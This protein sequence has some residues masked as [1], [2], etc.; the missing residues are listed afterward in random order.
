M[1][2]Q[3]FI[4][5][6]RQ[7]RELKKA[8][9][10]GKQEEVAGTISV[11]TTSGTISVPTT[12]TI[13]ETYISSPAGGGGGGGGSSGGGGGSSGGGGSA[14]ISGIAEAQA[15]EEA[16]LKAVEQARL[17]AIEDAKEQARLLEEK[18][19]LAEERKRKL[20]ESLKKQNEIK[21]LS[22]GGVRVGGVTHIGESIVSGTGGKTANQIQNEWWKKA[23]EQGITKRGTY[24]VDL[25]SDYY[26]PK[27]AGLE[28][29]KEDRGELFDMPLI[30]RDEEIYDPRTG[31]FISPSPTGFGATGFM[32]A[33]TPSEQARYDYAEL[34]GSRDVVLGGASSYFSLGTT[35]L[36]TDLTEEEMKKLYD[37]DSFIKTV[38]QV[39]NPITHFKVA[40]SKKEY[41]KSLES[42]NKDFTKLEKDNKDFENKWDSLQDKNTNLFLGSKDQYTKMKTFENKWDSLQDKNTNSFLGSED[43]YKQYAQEYEQ[44]AKESKQYA[45]EYEQYAK[46]FNKLNAKFNTYTSTPEYK[47]VMSEEEGRKTIGQRISESDMSFK[48]KLLSRGAIAGI[49]FAS[50]IN[51]YQRIV[52]GAESLLQG[53][54]VLTKAG[55]LTTKEKIQAGISVGVG[56]ILLKSGIRGGTA[57]LGKAGEKGGVLG[58]VAQW[59]KDLGIEFMGREGGFAR[60]SLGVLE[61][62]GVRT[63]T[64]MG[65]PV[66]LG[67][68]EAV[69]EWKQTGD[70]AVSL[71]AGLG[72]IAGIGLPMAF[73]KIRSGT[74]L[75][76]LETQKLKKGLNRL[77][78]SKLKFKQYIYEGSGSRPKSDKIILIGEQTS[79]T[80][81]RTIRLVGD[82][83][84]SNKGYMFFPKGEGIAETGGTI[85]IKG[86]SSKGFIDRIS[87]NTA[88]FSA[89]INLGSFQGYQVGVSQ[90][91][92]LFVPKLQMS[93]IFKVPTGRGIVLSGKTKIEKLK[94]FLSKKRIIKKGEGFMDIETNPKTII[95]EKQTE[96]F[97]TKAKKRFFDITKDTINLA[98]ISKGRTIKSTGKIFRKDSV[99]E[100][101]KF[102]EK[103]K[104]PTI[105]TKPFIKKTP[106]SKTFPDTKINPKVV[107]PTIKGKINLKQLNLKMV[108]PPL[109]TTIIK[110]GLA[111]R[112]QKAIIDTKTINIPPSVGLLSANIFEEQLSD[113]SLGVIPLSVLKGIS[114]TFQKTKAKGKVQTKQKIDVVSIQRGKIKQKEVSKSK[115]DSKQIQKQILV[116]PLIEPLITPKIS[117]KPILNL[118]PH[119]IP[120]PII[121]FPKKRLIKQPVKQSPSYDVFLKSKNKFSRINKKPLSLVN[122]RNLRDFG[123]DNSISRQGYLKP[124]Q[125]KPSP[126]QYDIN[127]NYSKNVA[128]KFRTFKQ[129]KGVK[130]KLPR[131]RKIELSKYALDTKAEKRQLSVF[132]LLAQREKKKIN[133]NKPSWKAFA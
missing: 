6:W 63:L 26:V 108:E 27:K 15:R 21:V 58:R 16:R 43:Q 61:R 51:P 40:I 115:I 130:T 94:Q 18:R 28:T 78:S 124:R 57:I 90:G 103:I 122:A 7:K 24:S 93:H 67:T 32:T 66:G 69:G 101:I 62:K 111:G 129:K 131:E 64:T 5:K 17:K 11:P 132:K 52:V 54:E 35:A 8:I 109:S 60:A 59:E 29:P 2:I 77:E 25:P 119:K 45:K 87:F 97:S 38:G 125:V 99:G 113:L 80:F 36:G 116:E 133:K 31:M 47:K 79:G 23:R 37:P 33:P 112:S 114:K 107:N 92:S 65:L 9:E 96:P 3:S 110:K 4:E 88:Q 42:V 102:T 117:V 68:L 56:A 126:L 72:T 71:G 104:P 34:L 20:Y 86:Q 100:F 14:G 50:Y 91:I 82:L 81:K 121:R 46:D 123:I 106:L 89:G 74:E 53:G 39:L 41:D 127:P 22:S 1:S 95:L 44:Y 75:T 19:R 118:R 85:K 10:K 83:L 12:S 73:Q 49:E 120:I 128:N 13:A 105:K 30:E 76:K 55:D 70:L 48:G 84:K 98:E